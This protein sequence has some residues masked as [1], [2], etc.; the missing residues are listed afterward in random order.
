MLRLDDIPLPAPGPGDVV[1][2]HHAVGVNFADIHNRTGRYPL[3]SLPHAIGG[4]AAGRVEAMGPDVSGF[5]PGDRVAYAAGGPD[6][7]PGAYAEARI[8]PA[9]RLILLP[10]KIHDAV[11]AS[12]MT[13]GIT[14]HYLLK[15]SYAVSAGE[16]IVVH[17]AAG[18]VGTLLAQWARHLGCRVIGVVGSEEKAAFAAENGCHHTIVS[19]K[20]DVA[21]RV[22]ELTA[23][24]GVPV[25]YDSVGRDT[26]GASLQCLAPHGTLVSFGSSSGKVPP[27][28]LFQLNRLGSLFVTS[29][30]FAWF[31]RERDE[32]LARASDLFDAVVSGAIRVHPPRRY[33]LSDA[34]TAHRDLEARR[35]SGASILVP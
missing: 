25:V 2:R 22:R 14:A 31:V 12:I 23:G 4:E 18:G 26:F 19:S 7:V 10:D 6:Y 20:E 34:A 35:T 33:A 16:T 11:A 27:F 17:A 21:K 30:G 15:S 3:P 8:F 24:R 1:V 13:K 32:L 29:P 9:D 28:D 5:K